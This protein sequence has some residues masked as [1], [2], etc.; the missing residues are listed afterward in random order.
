MSTSGSHESKHLQCE[1][2]DC[3]SCAAADASFVGCDCV[4]GSVVPGISKDHSA[5]LIRFKQSKAAQL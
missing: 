3:H 2:S 5:F 4:D 1:A